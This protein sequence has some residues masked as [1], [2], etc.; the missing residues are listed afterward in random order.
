MSLLSQDIIL[1]DIDPMWKEDVMS[2]LRGAGVADYEAIDPIVANSM[3]CPAMPLCGLAIGE[4]ER[5][6]PAV[7]ARLRSLMTKV[8]TPP[9]L[10]VSAPAD[11]HTGGGEKQPSAPVINGG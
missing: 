9:G 6:L 11:G 5:G 7:N 3:A 4:A 8:R 1:T 10:P 2:T